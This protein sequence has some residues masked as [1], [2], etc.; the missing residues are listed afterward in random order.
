M[1]CRQLATAA[2]VSAIVQLS[3]V[4]GE[5]HNQMTHAL[6]CGVSTSPMILLG[7]MYS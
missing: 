7:F 6:C 4:F 2:D 5:L 3:F 1:E